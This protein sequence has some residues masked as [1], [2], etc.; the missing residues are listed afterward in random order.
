MN[1]KA[2]LQFAQRCAVLLESGISLSEVFSIII[3]MEKSKKNLATLSSLQEKIERGVS[4]SKSIALTKAKFDPQLVSMIAHGEASGILAVSLRQAS[5]MMEKGS[6]IKKKIIGALIYPG[7]IAFA[8]IGMT[9]FLVM[10]I[11]PKIIPLFSS[12][13]ITLP[14]ITRIVRELYELTLH[15][16]LFMVIIMT[17]GYAIFHYLYFYKKNIWLRHRIHII[18]LTAPLIGNVVQKYFICIYCQSA[19]TLLECGQSLP[20]ILDQLATSSSFSPY[21][22]A[23]RFTRTEIERGISLSDSLRSFPTIFPTI[24]PDMLSIGERTGSLASMFHHVSRIYEQ[25]LEDFIKQLGTSIEPILMILMGL[26]VGSV[27]LSIILPIYEITNH[28]SK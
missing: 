22:K 25:E 16:G 10:Y 26:I 15:Y 9:L 23:W 6:G 7:F 3:R 21:Q 18:L 8:T 24:V 17:L 19:A 12:M 27:A 5:N 14:L 28:L 4:L 1:K 11:F 2:Q 13:N 20:T